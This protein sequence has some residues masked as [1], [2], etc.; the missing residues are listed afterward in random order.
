MCHPTLPVAQVPVHKLPVVSGFVAADLFVA[1]H[2][3]LIIDAGVRIAEEA[4]VQQ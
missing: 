1:L 4:R 2:C 3:V